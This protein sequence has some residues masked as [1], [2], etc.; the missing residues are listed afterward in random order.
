M[1]DIGSNP[2]K[3]IHYASIAKST[4]LI[5]MRSTV[6]IRLG[7]YLGSLTAAFFNT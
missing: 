5:R 2:I 4:C 6:G 7:A 3:A 1:R